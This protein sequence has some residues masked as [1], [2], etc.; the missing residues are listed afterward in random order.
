MSLLSFSWTALAI[1]VW[2]IT[3][4]LVPKERIG[5]LFHVGLV[6]GF[7]LAITINI[8]AVSVF[9]LW[10]YGP[11]IIAFNGIP[12]A[13]PIAWIAEIILYVHY[14]PEHKL[15]IVLYTVAFVVIGTIIDYFCLKFGMRVYLN[16]NL[17]SMFFLGLF[18]HA[19]VYAYY[20]TTNSEAKVRV[21]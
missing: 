20:Y 13:I 5:K 11:D 9:H 8:L 19:L 2:V 1:S 16:W 21:K 4:I 15:S 17:W 6:G 12:L 3:L 14:L 7:L 18:S 10:S